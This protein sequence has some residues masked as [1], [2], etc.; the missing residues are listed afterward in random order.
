MLS[1]MG[2]KFIT[3]KYMDENGKEI[4]GKVHWVYAFFYDCK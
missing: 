3:V 2:D 1:T 4:I